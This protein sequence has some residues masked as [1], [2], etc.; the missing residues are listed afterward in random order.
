M[1]NNYT[2]LN[3][4]LLTDDVIA[5]FDEEAALLDNIEATA[6]RIREA[7]SARWAQLAEAAI[8]RAAEAAEARYDARRDAEL[9]NG[10]RR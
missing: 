8:L 4:I 9:E 5:A 6:A 2:D 7:A 3:E 1:E 10:G